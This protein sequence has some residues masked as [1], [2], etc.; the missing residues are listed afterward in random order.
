MRFVAQTSSLMLLFLPVLWGCA[1]NSFALKQQTQSLQQQQVALQQRNQELQSRAATLD[2]DNQDLE[3]LLA[4]TRQQSKVVEDQLAAVREQLMT[5]SAQ[6]SQLRDEKQLTQKQTE[7]LMASVRRRAGA[8]ITANNSLQKNL[9]TLNLPGVEVRADGDVVRVELPADKLFQGDSVVL[10]PVAS[11]LLDTVALE[12]ARTYP[13]QQI[14]I[15]GHTSNDVVRTPGVGDHVQLST[16]RAAAV[17][18]F[19]VA[20]GQIP[21]NRLMVVGH[22]AGHPVVSNATAAG[23]AR[24]SRVEL[25]VYPES[26]SGQ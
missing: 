3:A 9:P 17:Y 22:G 12:I 13:N 20:R 10:Q 15:E 6:L 5:A 18:Q 14:G 23:K 21:A 16:A 7:A 2:R 11:A 1:D 26:P 8:Q 25:V 19:L 4:Q 24:N